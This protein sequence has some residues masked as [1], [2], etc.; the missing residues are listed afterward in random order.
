MAKPGAKCLCPPSA[1]QVDV[2][3]NL[4]RKVFSVNNLR[5]LQAANLSFIRGGHEIGVDGVL[6]IWLK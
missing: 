5:R 4:A 3:W 2:M 1:R 6:H